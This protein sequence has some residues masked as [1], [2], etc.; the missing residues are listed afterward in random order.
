M[1]ISLGPIPRFQSVLRFLFLFVIVVYFPVVI[2]L[3]QGKEYGEVTYAGQLKIGQNVENILSVT[4]DPGAKYRFIIFMHRDMLERTTDLSGHI[5]I[6]N[7]NGEEIISQDIT[8]VYSSLPSG[9][10]AFLQRDGLPTEKM[11]ENDPYY[12]QAMVYQSKSFEPKIYG[13]FET[14]IAFYELP[15]TNYSAALVNKNPPGSSPIL[16][17][18]GLIFVIFFFCSEIG[19][20]IKRV[21]IRKYEKT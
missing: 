13:E 8:S 19:Y 7:P 14:K 15:H 6:Y 16:L 5:S 2:Y 18:L 9:L 20:F 10:I 17:I 1:K 11:F 4:L 3:D 21:H 12:K